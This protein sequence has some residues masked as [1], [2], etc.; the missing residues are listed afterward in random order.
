V[1]GQQRCASAHRGRALAQ[2]ARDRKRSHSITPSRR[3]SCDR[4]RATQQPIDYRESLQHQ[5]A[6]T[7]SVKPRF[8][9]DSLQRRGGSVDGQLAP[10]R[11]GRSGNGVALPPRT[12]RVHSPL[13]GQRNAERLR[14]AESTVFREHATIKER[15][16]AHLRAPDRLALEMVCMRR[17][18]RG[19][20]GTSSPNWSARGAM[21]RRS[22]LSPTDCS[23]PP[24]VESAL[25][26]LRRTTE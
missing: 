12:A 25:D 10:E 5:K 11:S 2:H 6:R 20:C 18:R 13:D 23:R 14:W 3:T 9:F 24:P 19:R 1:V 4:E 16:P 15:A 17:R 8:R 26:K 22:P 7:V 21:T